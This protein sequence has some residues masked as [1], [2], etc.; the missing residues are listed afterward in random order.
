MNGITYHEAIQKPNNVVNTI[1]HDLLD[2]G[3]KNYIELVGAKQDRYHFLDNGFYWFLYLQN[4]D[5]IDI[6]LPYKRT[7]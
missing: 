4:G 7:T 1:P 3:V 5:R 6:K 2:D